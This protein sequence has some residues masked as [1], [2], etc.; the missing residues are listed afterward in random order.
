M[1]DGE[2]T[3]PLRASLNGHR[4]IA[5]LVLRNGADINAPD[6]CLGRFNLRLQWQGMLRL[7]GNGVP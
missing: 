6:R 7:P 2:G 3:T 4:E 1:K 5:E